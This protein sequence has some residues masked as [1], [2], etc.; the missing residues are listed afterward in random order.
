MNCEHGRNKSA[1]PQRAGHL[2]QCNEKK[3]YRNRVQQD[4]RKVMPSRF[5]S[6]ELAV[7][8]VRHGRQRMPVHRNEHEL[9][10]H[11]MPLRLRPLVILV[12]S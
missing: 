1:S 2:L 7:E 3:N 9:K 5:Q 10:A 4:V 6:I 12:F 11:P 8:H